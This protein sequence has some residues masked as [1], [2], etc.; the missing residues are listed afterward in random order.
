MKTKPCSAIAPFKTSEFSTQLA[1]MESNRN[2]GT[3]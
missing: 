3:R 2:N 1:C